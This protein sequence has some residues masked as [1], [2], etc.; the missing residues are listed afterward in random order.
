M[1]GFSQE[2]KELLFSFLANRR[3][4]VKLNGIFSDCEVLN[5]GVPQGT[6]LGP[7]IF[8]LYVNDFSSNIST[9]EK[10]IQLADDTSIVCCGQKGSL[11]G[12]VPEMLQKT[13]EYVETNKLTLNTNKTEL[14]FFSRDSSWFRIYFLQKRCSYN[15]KKLQL[16]WY[17]NWQE[18]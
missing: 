9:T 18:S 12:K 8:L 16:S 5:H 10:V 15:T 13:E 7:L 4:K 6:V 11:H 3:Q 2:A 17:S 14:I 1:Y